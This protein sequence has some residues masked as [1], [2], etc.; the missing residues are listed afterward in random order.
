MHSRPTLDRFTLGPKGRQIVLFF[1]EGIALSAFEPSALVLFH[2]DGTLFNNASLNCSSPRRGRD[3]SWRE[4]VL[5]LDAPCPMTDVS[6]LIDN[7]THSGGNASVDFVNGF[8]NDWDRLIES[9]VLWEVDNW[10]NESSE[11]VLLSALPALLTDLS[12]A[13]NP[14]VAVSELEQSF[15]GKSKYWWIP[16]LFYISPPVGVLS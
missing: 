2:T 9:G 7:S 10:G 8:S 15:P 6:L 11:T 13:G 5:Q 12:A 4:I 1:S 16:R 14:L 3:D